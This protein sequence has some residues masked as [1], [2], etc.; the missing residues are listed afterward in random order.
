MQLYRH[1]QDIGPPFK[2]HDHALRRNY[3]DQ[4]LLYVV[5]TSHGHLMLS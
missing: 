1:W 2:A 5:Y 3:T 4:L